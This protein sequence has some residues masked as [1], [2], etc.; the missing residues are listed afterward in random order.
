MP[1]K[2]ELEQKLEE[3]SALSVFSVFSDIRDTMCIATRTM[4]HQALKAE[5]IVDIATDAVLHSAE[6]LDATTRKNLESVNKPTI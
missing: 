3:Q 5:A 2:A 6:Y 4:R 1:T